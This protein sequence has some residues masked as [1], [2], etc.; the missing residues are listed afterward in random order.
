MDLKEVREKIDTIDEKIADLF[1]ARMDEVE[2]VTEIKKANNLPVYSPARER[3]VLNKVS[4]RVPGKYE[5]YARV[6][7]S[8]M[9]ELSRSIKQAEREFRAKNAGKGSGNEKSFPEPR[10]RLPGGGRRVFSMAAGKLFKLPNIL[11]FR[12]LRS[13]LRGGEGLCKYG[14]LPIENSSYGSSTTLRSDAQP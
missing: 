1:A 6:L 13:V 14:V 11:Y 4:D 7:F 2:R 12:H 3:E 9:F 10:C 8:T 5:S